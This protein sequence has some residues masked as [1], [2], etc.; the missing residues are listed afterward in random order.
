[1]SEVTVIW[2]IAWRVA[3][4]RSTAGTGLSG[5]PSA[6][7]REDR[8]PGHVLGSPV[9]LPEPSQR[10]LF[11]AGK[12]H[13]FPPVPVSTLADPQTQGLWGPVSLGR[14]P[15]VRMWP[16]ERF[17]WSGREQGGRQLARSPAASALP[18]ARGA[19]SAHKVRGLAQ[20]PVLRLPRLKPLGDQESKL[21][22]RGVPT[23]HS[24]SSPRPQVSTKGERP[25]HPR[26]PRA[27]RMCGAGGRIS[28]SLTSMPFDLYARVMSAN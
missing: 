16:W 21:L 22:G 26:G 17:P 7:C 18:W 9:P 27:A 24:Q 2:A 3:G 14:A 13:T 1:M 5:S 6:R 15:K 12:I 25:L 20:A 4:H 23:S 19:A 28:R 8:W 11:R 10:R